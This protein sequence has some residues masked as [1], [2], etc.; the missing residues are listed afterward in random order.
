MSH[1]NLE[2]LHRNR[3][4]YRGYPDNDEPTQSYWWGS[5]Y[6]Q[7]TYECYELFR[8]KAKI[9]TYRSLKWHLL[10]LWYLNSQLDQDEF[11]G[12]AELIAD[13]DNGFTSFN[14]PPDLLRKIVYEVSMLDL[15]EPPKN[16][17]RKII[18]KESCLLSKREKLVIV[19][20][21]IGRSKK[22]QEDDIYECM[23]N[24]NDLGM[25][26]TI[27]RLALKLSCTARTIYRH[28]STELKKEKELLN[29]QL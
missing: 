1:R 6:Q 25:L 13:R 23:L 8:T 18:F 16:K 12:I 9:T 22:I 24:L 5:Y 2:Y 19:G 26:I 15:D 11:L 7:G 27:S 14:M 3:I 29:Q 17:A 21:I 10:V 4:I 20:Q 28:M